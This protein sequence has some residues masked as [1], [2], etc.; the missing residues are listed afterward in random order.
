LPPPALFAAFANPFMLYGM[1]AASI[2]IVIHLLNKR[3]YRETQW[4]AMRFLLAAIRKNSRRIRLE[5]LL[6]LAV[7][8]LLVLLL[9]AALA[10]P[11][12]ENIGA[13]PALVGQRTHRVLVLDGSLSMDY[14]VAGSTRFE[15]A[16]EVAA[17]FVKE[18]RRGDVISVVLMGDPPRDI[19]EKPSPKHDEVLK[20]LAAITLPHGGIDLTASFS[21][22]NEVL[23][24]ST[25]GQKE[26]VILTDLQ[27]ASWQPEGGAGDALQRSLA[28]LSGFKPRSVVVDLGAAG[29]ENVAVTD[30]SVNT[31]IVTLGA[32]PAVS[33]T[34][35]DFG[36]K[37]AGEVRATFFVDGQAVHEQAV[38]LKPGEDQRVAFPYAFASAGDHL[39]EARI[40]D[41]PLKLDNRRCLAVPVRE[42]LRVLLVDGDSRS[43]PFASDSDYLAQ[44]L[45]PAEASPGNP[46]LIRT[47]VVSESQLSR[48]D[49]APFDAVVLCNIAQFN[50]AEV[51][52]LEAYLKQGGGLVVFGG[53]QVLP[54]NY[55]RL[56]HADGKGLL[57]AEVGASVGDAATKGETRFTFDPL[58]YRDPMV[59]DFQGQTDAVQAGLN[60]VKTWEY[61]KLKLP[62][63]SSAKVAMNF[64]TGDP[65]I[66]GSAPRLGGSSRGRVIQV[67][68]S[69]DAGWTTWPLHPS[70][71]VVM[72]QVILQAA[73][74]RR[75]DRNVRVGQPLDQALPAAGA[76]L[77]ATV[78]LP[79]GKV[80]PTKLRAEG[81]VSRLAFDRTDL[82][83]PY[84]VRIGPPL[85]VDSLFAAN[86]D[87]AESD[88]AKLDG[89]GLKAALPGWDFQY[90]ADWHRLLGGVASVGRRGELHR[91]LLYAV[92][93]LLIV[94]SLL[95]WRF[96][97]HAPARA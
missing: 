4:A 65:A 60:G 5:Q 62:K 51:S 49:L 79:D 39:V 10:R 46:S 24:A 37:G 61:H 90:E 8:T 28:R 20:E 73:A 59:A 96:G 36:R 23:A 84:Q 42:F 12:L 78:T 34:I 92:L 14:A 35:R 94:E 83:G 1:A 43:E 88:P 41:D 53:D 68:T 38:A 72:E 67:A 2:P 77:A 95:A 11:Y 93:T 97:H 66:I 27:A 70:Y 57:P 22:I 40:D 16:K 15:R 91:M 18:A 75:A 50:E 9:V 29:G 6:L 80:E 31:P 33:A 74:G 54:E 19:I 30:L 69:A 87:P 76:N 45:N 26:V 58:G 3:K 32:T 55:N 86:P 48:Q 13:I 82:S 44:A 52:A 21:K 71:P 85:S 17:Q 7:R 47:E 63:G 56:L 81:D 89:A 64:S 25:I